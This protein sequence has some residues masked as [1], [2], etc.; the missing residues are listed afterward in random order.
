MSRGQGRRQK[1]RAIDG[2]LLLDKPIGLTS[3]QALQRVKRLFD[4]RKAGHTGSLDPLASGLLPVCLGQATK[5]SGFLLDARKRY[6]VTARLG[7]RTDTGDADGQVVE[8]QPVPPLDDDAVKRVLAQFAGLQKQVP[9]MYSAIK[10]QGQRLYKLARRGIEI[11]RQPR[12]I[13]IYGLE[14]L[15]LEADALELDV[16]CSKG[17]YVRTLIEDI[18]R[19]LG[20]VAHVTVLRRLGVGPYAE[21]R[22]YKLEELEALAEQG[23]ERLDDVLLPV[24]SA[25]DHWP[26]VELGADSAYYLMQGQAVMAPGAPSSGKV[27]LYDEGHGF[28]GI[29]EVKL[30][31]RVAPTRL[32]PR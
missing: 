3:N 24:D 27:R 31:G 25:L 16:A 9:P 2:V 12:Q 32:F 11:E 28:L 18:A 7:Q 17:T 10:H 21:G 20:T 22:M 30:D 26:S 13:E 29:G 5:V 14:L 23:M 4:A 6:Q 8:E 15:S 19:A 1:G